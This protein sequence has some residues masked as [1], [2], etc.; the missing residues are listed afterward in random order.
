[1]PNINK[2]QRHLS[3]FM[4]LID[5][6]ND[7]VVKKSETPDF[8][9]QID[10]KLIGVEHTELYLDKDYPLQAK[11]SIED[12]I[13]EKAQS[14]A[15]YNGYIP[16]RTK[17][18]FHNVRGLK[19][20]QRKNIASKLADF[21][22][23]NILQ[24]NKKP[25]TQLRLEP[26]IPVVSSVYATVMPKD[27]K[28]N[29]YFTARAGWVKEDASEEIAKAVRIKSKKVS[30]YLSKCDEVWLL[31]VAD[32]FKPSSLLGEGGNICPIESLAG[33]KKV[34][35]M[36]YAAKTLLEVPVEKVESKNG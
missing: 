5:L 19:E 2:E 1:M 26:D 11:E 30:S 18:Q 7:I 8:L 6:D 9:F 34:Y 21:V 28:K 33:F 31:I 10:G 13:A 3:V 27:F 35:F 4:K 15:D 32:G 24:S 16:T 23:F 12:D 29:H 17:I 25:F 22:H 36:S 20:K 14:Y